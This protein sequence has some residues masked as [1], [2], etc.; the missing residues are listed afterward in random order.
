MARGLGTRERIRQR[1]GA[2]GQV[3]RRLTLGWRR[4]SGKFV[5]SVLGAS[6]SARE[7][8]HRAGDPIGADPTGALKLEWPLIQILPDLANKYIGCSVKL[9]LQINGE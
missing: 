4:A 1:L 8:C 6:I 5:G 2:A 3:P 9:E 7:G